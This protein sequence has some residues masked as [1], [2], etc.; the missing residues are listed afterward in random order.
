MFIYYFRFTVCITQK[1]RVTNATN[2]S[3]TLFRYYR[4]AVLDTLPW[5]MFMLVAFPMCVGCI[6]MRHL[7]IADLFPFNIKE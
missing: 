6:L 3:C 4:R 5:F 1:N 7:I 2:V